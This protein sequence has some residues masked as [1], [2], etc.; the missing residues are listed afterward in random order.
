M[1]DITSCVIT[2]RRFSLRRLNLA[3]TAKKNSVSYFV[4][5]SDTENCLPA[6]VQQMNT[7]CTRPVQPMC[8]VQCCVTEQCSHSTWGHVKIKWTVKY[9]YHQCPLMM[10]GKSS[11]PRRSW[12]M[13]R[14]CW[15][16]EVLRETQCRVLCIN[17]APGTIHVDTTHIYAGWSHLD[18]MLMGG[19]AMLPVS[20]G[21][22]P[23]L[24]S[25]CSCCCPL[26]VVEA[27]RVSGG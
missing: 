26:A 16:G 7:Q 9:T 12:M 2:P 1:C 3:L 20:V 10:K 22:A 25:P 11:L 5:N 27:P 23:P 21:A 18:V 19:P 13:L 6:K 14:E 15:E 4:R 24:P 17:S 8:F